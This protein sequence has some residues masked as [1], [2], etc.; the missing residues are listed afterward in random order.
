[1]STQI[2]ELQSLIGVKADGQ[3]GPATLKAAR[4][5]F[6]L[7][8]EQA[9]HFFGQCAHE[10]GEF[11]IFEENLNYSAQG[12]MKVFKKYFPTESATKQYAKKPQWIANKV[13]G[14][15]MGNGDENSGD[16][17]KFRGRGALQ[18]TGKSNYQAFAQYIGS[19][20]VLQDPDLVEHQYAFHT[21][22]FFFDRNSLWTLC[23]TVT[24]ASITSVTKR[25]NGGVNGLDHRKALTKKFY[26]WLK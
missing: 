1:M 24:D 9:A 17:W 18:L 20:V 13:Y 2:K 19:D 5:Y 16:G 7:T 26:G 25:V 12:L 14:G 3:F 8:N 15:R 10:T 23:S 6:K 22:K 11:S 4:Q 21:A